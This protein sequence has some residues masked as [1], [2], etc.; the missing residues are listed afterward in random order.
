M[1]ILLVKVESP[2]R[3]N[4]LQDSFI[5]PVRQSVAYTICTLL[6]DLLAGKTKH[7]AMLYFFL[8]ENFYLGLNNCHTEHFLVSKEKQKLWASF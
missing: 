2:K 7:L 8:L 4:L 5:F 6:P 3:P 1:Q